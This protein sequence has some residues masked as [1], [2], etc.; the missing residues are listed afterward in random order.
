M[1]PRE[2]VRAL[3]GSGRDLPPKVRRAVLSLGPA[4]IPV[5]LRL[6]EPTEQ[7][8]RR[9]TGWGDVHAMNLLG[10]I[11]AVEA[12]P[13]IIDV[14]GRSDPMEIR[15]SAAIATLTSLGDAA[16]EP[17]LAAPTSSEDFECARDDVLASLG[18]GDPRILARLLAGLVHNPMLYA[19]LIGKRADPEALPGLHAAFDRLPIAADFETT[20]GMIEF[21]EAIAACGGSLDGDQ[22][23]KARSIEALGRDAA[24]HPSAPRRSGGVGPLGHS[25]RG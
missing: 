2:I 8:S 17:L 19:C 18:F 23:R 15:Y 16:V 4:A 11:G 6:L 25:V 5:L 20:R 24:R 9:S 10:E 12:I 14:L 13:E 1:L 7:E 3:V 21:V 22:I